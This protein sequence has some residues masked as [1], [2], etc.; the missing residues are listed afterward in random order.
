MEIFM[1]TLPTI[2]IVLQL[3]TKFH[4]NNVITWIQPLWAPTPPHLLTDI[5]E[6]QI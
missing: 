2:E 5:F 3:L 1:V 4:K 6:I